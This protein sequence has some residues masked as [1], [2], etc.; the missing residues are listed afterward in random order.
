MA[1]LIECS[2]LIPQADNE[3]RP[4]ERT[5][6]AELRDRI[7]LVS[8]GAVTV[9]PGA[10]GE[11]RDSDGAVYL[12]TVDEYVAGVES[13]R[14]VASWLALA[15]WALTTFRQEAIYVKV[16]PFAEVVFPQ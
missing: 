11:W 4:F 16:G 9:W 7:V 1:I 10:Q 3:G 6:L 5:V 13:L 14:D 15:D 2:I 12:D 8:K